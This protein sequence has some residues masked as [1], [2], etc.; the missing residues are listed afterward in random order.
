MMDTHFQ[1]RCRERGIVSTDLDLLFQGIS[2]AIDNAR[3]DLVEM[4]LK[5]K[6]A[7]FWRFRC[8]DGIFYAVTC[9]RNGRPQTVL[10]QAMMRKKK[11][12]A[13]KA[14]RNSKSLVSI[15]AMGYE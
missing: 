6:K 13:R 15:G 12:A 5:T 7:R 9:L 11:F 14:R 3:D 1:N 8:P 10:T 2:W 4:V